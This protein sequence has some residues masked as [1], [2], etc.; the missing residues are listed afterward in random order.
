MKITACSIVKNEAQNIA[1][2]IESYRAA[3]DE[4]IIVDTGST[5]E[6]VKICCE[7]GAK[8]LYFPWNSNFAEAKNYALENAKGDWVVFLDADEWFNPKADRIQIE[9]IIGSISSIADGLMVEMCEYDNVRNRVFAHDLATRIFRNR[10]EIRYFGSIHEIL[11]KNGERLVVTI[12]REIKIYHSGYSKDILPQKLKRNLENLYKIYNNGDI[13]TSNLYYLFRENYLLKN[14][15]E[16]TKF[17]KLFMD[18]EDA[19]IVIEK[20]NSFICIYEQMYFIMERHMDRYTYNDMNC[21]ILKAFNKYPKQPI[22][23][24][25]IGCQLLQN[26]SYEDSLK[27]LLQAIELNNSYY[28]KYVNSFVGYLND[29]YCKIGYIYERLQLN[30]KA[31]TY[32]INALKSPGATDCLYII[33]NILNIIESQPQEEIIIFLNTILDIKNIEVIKSILSA[34]KKTRLH[35]VFIYYAIKYNKEFDGQDESTYI[36]MI[37]SG[38]AETSI[39]IAIE[40]YNNNKANYQIN[41]VWHLDYALIGI[42]YLKEIRI[43]NMYKIYFTDEQNEIIFAYLANKKLFVKNYTLLEQHNKISQMIF[44]IFTEEER[45]RFKSII[46]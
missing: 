4:I 17:Y 42:L 31:L 15:D 37:L 2:S 46:E 19:D 12:S 35:K 22:F 7:L 11:K 23:S 45:N 6:T 26:H 18:R 1:R 25:L 41:S 36:A 33:P 44:Y 24:Y 27:W 30:D 9:S 21:L 29:S 32:Y 38:Q 16:A 13:S 3:V 28:E 10:P 5:D 8:V 14:D 43:Y 34:L 20:F 40:S 39:E